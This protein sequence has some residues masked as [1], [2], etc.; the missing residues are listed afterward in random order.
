MHSL[1][2][3][4][5]LALAASALAQNIAYSPSGSRTLEGGDNNTIPLWSDSATYMQIHDHENMDATLGGQATPLLGL[6]LRKD[7]GGAPIAGRTFTLQITVSATPVTTRSAS[8]SFAAN[9]GGGAV[10]VLPFGQVSFP[11]LIDTAVPNPPGIVVPWATPF[12][13]TPTP[14]V[15]LCWEWRHRAA[16]SRANGALDAVN[17]NNAAIAANEGTGCVAGGQFSA[18]S[19]DLVSLNLPAQT[20]QNRLAR[21]A[22]SSGAVFLLGVQRTTLQLPGQCAPVLTNPLVFLPGATDATGQWDLLFSTPDLRPLGRAEILGQFV[23]VDPTLP[24]GFGVSDMS[25]AITPL[26]GTYYMGRFYAAPYNGGA[27]FDTATNAMGSDLGYGLV[28][29]FMTP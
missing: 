14:G 4:T 21:G 22:V 8:S 13:F 10:V 3:L 29:G 17:V 15:S 20:Y 11:T 9:L 19:I 18:A 26:R 2:A 16:T 23:W 25:V 12:P 27:G 7:A 6:T 24:V 5:T 28:V 1:T